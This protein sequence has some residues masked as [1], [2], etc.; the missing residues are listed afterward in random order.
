MRDPTY[1]LKCAIEGGKSYRHLEHI[2]RANSI[3]RGDFEDFKTRKLTKS[4]ID[5]LVAN[6]NTCLPGTTFSDNVYTTM[7]SGEAL[8]TSSIRNCSFGGS[9]IVLGLLA[10]VRQYKSM[11]TVGFLV[12]YS[13]VHSSTVSYLTTVLC[14]IVRC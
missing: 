8:E 6:G 14:V 3:F 13:T 1:E 10:W 12:A 5:M 7:R 4:E 9:R 11:G 2:S